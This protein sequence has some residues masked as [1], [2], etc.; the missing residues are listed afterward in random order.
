[1]EFAPYYPETGRWGSG[2]LLEAAEDVFA[3][4]SR[5]LA[6]QFAQAS[7]PDP[8]VLAAAHFAAITAGFCGSPAAGMSWLARHASAPS[9]PSAPPRPVLAEA[10][11]LADPRGGWAALRAVPGGQ[12]ITAAFAPRTQAIARY[13]TLL[14]EAGD[15]DADAV[16]VSLLH[17]H[18]IRAAGINRDDEH[19]CLRLARA[20]ALSYQARATRSQA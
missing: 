5:A 17:A 10:V 13:R 6:A 3:A 7:R 12:A 20:A 8:R 15:L 19:A 18:H 1:M 9:S 11:R 2:P 16:L 4:D 14:D